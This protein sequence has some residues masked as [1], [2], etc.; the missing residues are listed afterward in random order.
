MARNTR[1][2]KKTRHSSLLCEKMSFTVPTG[3]SE[4]TQQQLRKIISLYT[5]Y[6]ERENGKEMI[7]LASLFYFMGIRVDGEQNEGILCYKPESGE[8][9]FLDPELLPDMVKQV[10]WV[11]HPEQITI[12]MEELH[13]CK[14]VAFDL[15]DLPFGKYL[16]CENYYQ[17]WVASHK[18]PA[19]GEMLSRLY[20][21]PEGRKIACTLFDSYSVALWWMGVKS[22]YGRFYPHLFKEPSGEGV[23][24]NQENQLEMM[25]AQI[26]ML[27][28]G[29]VT[30]ENEILNHTYTR[31]AL[32]ELDA[33]AREAEEIKKMM[34]E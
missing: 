11:S 30:K 8:T 9:F 14:A 17:A 32:T 3:W 20:I 27:T 18:F 31:R 2:S 28:K 22:L 21:V 5:L 13:G 15:R 4:L 34:K 29:D 10:E 25:D 19:L 33:Q 1:T 7:Q 12:R 26:R 23:E 24:I 16:E 6:D